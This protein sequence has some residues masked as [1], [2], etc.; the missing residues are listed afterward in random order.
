MQPLLFC[1]QRSFSGEVT[2]HPM[3]AAAWRRGRGTEIEIL[4][5]RA[6]EAR[7]GAK[8]S[9]AQRH[10]PTDD[11]AANKVGVAL[12]QICR[13]QHRTSGNAIA[14]TRSKAFDLRFN[15]RAHVA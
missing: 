15:R 3:S 7:C 11:V 13:G 6:I 5:R 8:K 1:G 14:K 2:A 10:C 4:N 12:F 9:L